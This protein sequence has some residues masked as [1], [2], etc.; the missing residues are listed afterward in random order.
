MDVDLEQL[1]RE[2]LIDLIRAERAEANKMECK[3]LCHQR[4][5]FRIR[6]GTSCVLEGFSYSNSSRRK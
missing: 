4:P 3:I 5:L 1:S 6:T 2:E